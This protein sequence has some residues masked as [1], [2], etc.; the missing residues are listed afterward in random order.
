MKSLTKFQDFYSARHWGLF[1]QK[2]FFPYLCVTPS[3]GVHV[4]DYFTLNLEA[5]QLEQCLD[6]DH[7]PECLTKQETSSVGK[8]NWQALCQ[9]HSRLQPVMQCCK[10]LQIAR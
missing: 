5:K 1:I 10:C 9:N 2:L 6:L 4:A 8:I 7:R 3:L